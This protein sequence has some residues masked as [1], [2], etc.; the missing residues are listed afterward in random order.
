MQAEAKLD[1]RQSGAPLTVV[2]HRDGSEGID[3]GV[4]RGIADLDFVLGPLDLERDQD[5]VADELQDLAALRGRGRGT[6][7]E[8]VIQQMQQVRGGQRFGQRGE[9]AQVRVLER[10]LDAVA[11]A[12]LHLALQDA[13]TDARADKSVEKA[14]RHAPSVNRLKQRRQQVRERLEA[15]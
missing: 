5:R 13:R 9:A 6:V 7:L 10:C 1:L 12:A 3:R 8:V 11:V 15:L 14:E 2:H 4:E